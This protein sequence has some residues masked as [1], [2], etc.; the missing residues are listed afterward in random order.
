MLR[1]LIL[2]LSLF[3]MPALAD[4]VHTI[5]GPRGTGYLGHLL[6]GPA[7]R[8]ENVSSREDLPEAFDW[9]EH[10]Q[11]PPIKDQG[12]CGSCW[13]QAITK[14]LESVMAIKGGKPGLDLAEQEL[15][16]CNREAAGCSGGYMESAQYVVDHGLGLES[17][18]PYRAQNL[19]CKKVPVAAKAVSYKLIG[20][21]NKK[22]TV[23]QMK[24]AL[25]DHGPLFVTVAAGSGWSGQGVELTYCRN[26][27]INH[28]VTLVG[29][30]ADGKWIM[31]NSWGTKWNDKGY[32]LMKFG[33]DKIGDEAGFVTV[34]ELP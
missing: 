22:P 32:T 1:F 5:N 31:A 10:V 19:R 17:D 6:G 13:A 9:R 29:W 8:Y 27:S 26:R 23:A 28:M 11:L 21:S 3:S 33:C 34:D 24:T 2:C 14:A 12:A 16:S 25:Y 18:F 30:T 20:E 4:G 15:V 7:I